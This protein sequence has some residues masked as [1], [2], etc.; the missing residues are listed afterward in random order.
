MQPD[1]IR[2]LFNDYDADNDGTIDF[3]EFCALL[4]AMNSDIQ[5]EARRVAFDVVDTDGNGQIEF[6]EFCSWWAGKS[7]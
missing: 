2:D 4:D 6:G 5:V 1:D 7:R 3:T